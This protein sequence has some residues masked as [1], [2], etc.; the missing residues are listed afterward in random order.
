MS[1]HIERVKGWTLLGNLQNEGHPK[2]IC[3]HSLSNSQRAWPV[4]GKAGLKH[5]CSGK[6]TTPLQLCLLIVQ[7]GEQ[8]HQWENT[9]IGP[10]SRK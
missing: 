10:S 7:A 6:D 9:Q 5:F 4:E 2:E 8:A 3:C 1:D